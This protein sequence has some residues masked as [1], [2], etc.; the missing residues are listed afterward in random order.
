MHYR[1]SF[2]SELLW[3]YTSKER[4]H[5]FIDL[6]FISLLLPHATLRQ[7]IKCMGTFLAQQLATVPWIISPS[8]VSVSWATSQSYSKP[9]LYLCTSLLKQT[10]FSLTKFEWIRWRHPHTGNEIIFQQLFTSLATKLCFLITGYSCHVNFDR[11]NCL[12]IHCCLQL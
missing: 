12:A 2:F 7:P 4:F 3:T 6:F 11:L 10:S 8:F 9:D 1:Q 5:R